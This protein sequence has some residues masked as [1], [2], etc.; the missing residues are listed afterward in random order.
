M[1]TTVFCGKVS[2]E[3][4]AS[5]TDEERKPEILTRVK[6]LLDDKEVIDK[7]MSKYNKKEETKE[8]YEANR[9]N[10]IIELLAIA[11]TNY[12]EYVEEIK[13]SVRQGYSI[14]LER[15][16]DE[17]YIN[18]FN[19]EW[20]EA[21]KGNIDLQ[22]TLDYFAVITYVTDYLTKDESGVT[23]ILREVMKRTEKDETKERMQMMINT[24]LT[25]RQMGQAEAYYKLIPSL[26]MKFSTVK[27]VF[28]PTDKKE[29]RSRFLQKVDK[30]EET[31]DK[32]AFEVNGREGLFIE[33]SDLIEKY[34]RRPGT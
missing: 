33:K 2:S 20:L 10:R 28:I 13:H 27:T 26:H 17:G 19:P 9:N 23:A 15:D 8:E 3:N 14:L 4:A 21:W 7:I 12:E 31:F 1:K 24:F 11:E 32:I 18:A 6:E 16:I 34:I 30:K 29:L 5:G 25:H 22:P